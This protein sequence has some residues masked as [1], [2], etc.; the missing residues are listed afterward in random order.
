MTTGGGDMHQCPPPLA[1]PLPNSTITLPLSRQKLG[2]HRST[3]LDQAHILSSQRALSNHG[4]SSDA[5][6]AIRPVGPQDTRS[7]NQII[8]RTSRLKQQSHGDV[9]DKAQPPLHITV[10]AIKHRSPKIR[11][12]RYV[13]PSMLPNS[14][15]NYRL[16]SA[17]K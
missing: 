17:S 15:T 2:L 13:K 12:T 3:Q 7:E 4:L 9:D 14:R 5:S 16:A 10:S 6:Q 1:T 8:E 11:S